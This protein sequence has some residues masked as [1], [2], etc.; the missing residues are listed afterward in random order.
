MKR[1]VFATLLM[2]PVV[3]LLF[4][5]ANPGVEPLPEPISNNAVAILRVKGQ[6]ELFSLMG[7]GPKKTWDAVT[8]AAYQLDADSGK[9]YSIHA[10]PGTA[11]R[12]GAMAVG[13]ANH[14]FLSGGR[15]GGPGRGQVRACQRPLVSTK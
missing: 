7:M 12:I 11:G 1:L 10:V 3:V 9:V 4:A 8:N 14:V 13:A 2:L 15:H 5:A 6:L